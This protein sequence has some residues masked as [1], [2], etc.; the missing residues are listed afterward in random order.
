MK[1]K[2]IVISLMLITAI[3]ASGCAQNPQ[4]NET[5]TNPNSDETIV[6]GSKLFQES[7]ILA[8]MLSILLEENGYNTEV[9]QGLGGT[10]VNFEALKQGQIDAYVEYTGT[11]YS[12][13]L[14]N[15]SPDTWESQMIY[16]ETKEGMLEEENIVIANRLGF[17]NAYAIAVDEEWAESHNI[18]KLSDLEGYASD[19]VVGTDP[20]FATRKD[21]LPQIKEV[22]DFE[23]RDY[24]QG[25]PSIMYKSIK[26]KQVDAISAYTTDTKNE[27]FDLRVLN[28]D[29]A[30]LPPYD[31]ITIVTSD[32]ASRHQDAMDV[33]GQLNNTID[34]EKMRN[35]NY[36]YD[37]ENKEA[38]DIAR[39]FLDK[40]GLIENS[41]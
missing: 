12:Q 15:P 2:V 39:N 32:F 16:K 6:I 1:W 19:M 18:T 30:A 23:F 21:G 7:Y 40:E 3:M 31:A 9:E 29:N 34:Q 24:K 10:F 11:A 35:L 41:N 14:K 25:A 20:E 38:R 5:D 22:Y 28:D 33:F 36:Q 26:N 37:V 8:H 13:I 17:E 4:T 27:L